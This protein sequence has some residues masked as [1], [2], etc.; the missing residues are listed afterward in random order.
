MRIVLRRE[1]VTELLPL[2]LGTRKLANFDSHFR[3]IAAVYRLRGSSFSSSFFTWCMLWCRGRFLQ[4]K[5]VLPP[6]R[7]ES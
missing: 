2:A 5:V 3:A 7:P 4:N 1:H 6:G